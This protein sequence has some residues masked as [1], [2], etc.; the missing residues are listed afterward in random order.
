MRLKN[1]FYDPSEELP[2]GFSRLDGTVEFFGRVNSLLQPEF[3]VLDLGAGRGAWFFED[4]VPFRRSLR[5]IK[6]KVSEYIGADIDDVVLSNPTTT[7]NVL[8]DGDRLPLPD[9]SVDLI[10]CDYVLEHIVDV[11]SFCANVSRVLRPGGFLCG[12]TPHLLNY[13]SL[14]AR[15]VTNAQ[16]SRLL[17]FAQPNR[18]PADIFPTVYRCNTVKTLSRLFPGWKNHSYLYAAEPQYY[19]GLKSV[20]FLL[21]V[22]H[23]FFP[24]Y[25]TGN[26][27]VFL[28]KPPG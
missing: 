26:I 23:R 2:G 9:Q 22:V 12:R 25:L 14:I 6:S 4:R 13:V 17:A 5:D 1:A 20:Y 10:I 11:S 7:R 19:F 24:A 18:K 16:H 8:I 3:R 27:F 15:L 28:R 21:S